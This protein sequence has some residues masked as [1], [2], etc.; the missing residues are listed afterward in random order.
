METHR[1]HDGIEEHGYEFYGYGGIKGSSREPDSLE[2]PNIEMPLPNIKHTK[3]PR[4]V[5]S[6]VSGGISKTDD[7]AEGVGGEEDEPG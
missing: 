4:N 2:K 7:D 1:T 5:K 3:P 6:D